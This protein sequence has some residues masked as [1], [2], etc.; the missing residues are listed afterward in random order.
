M[1]F[2]V[3]IINVISS[4]IPDLVEYGTEDEFRA[5]WREIFAECES[6]ENE[7]VIPWNFEN[8]LKVG[9]LVD[10]KT[11]YRAETVY[12]PGVAFSSVDAL[13]IC[14]VILNGRAH[15]QTEDEFFTTPSVALM[16][17]N[18]IVGMLVQDCDSLRFSEFYP[19]QCSVSGR[20]M[21]QGWVWGEGSFYTAT[22]FDTLHELRNDY[23]EQSGL[24]D[25]DLLEWAYQQD[26]L[27]WTTWEIDTDHKAIRACLNYQEELNENI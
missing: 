7:S 10:H 5:A 22:K 6:S 11:E 12:P 14:D 3:R 20:G 23:A 13:H 18:R 25:D 16:M 21:F 9:Y 1:M 8:S 24:P 4:G 27:Y 26:I 15:G 2:E 19:R 17:Y